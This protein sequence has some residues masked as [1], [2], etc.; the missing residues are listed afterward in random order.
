MQ[1]AGAPSAVRV[2]PRMSTIVQS[3]RSRG[4][5]EYRVPPYGRGNFK[6]EKIPGATLASSTMGPTCP[7]WYPQR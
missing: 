1:A 3:T 6:V 4:D 7:E 2:H 5:A